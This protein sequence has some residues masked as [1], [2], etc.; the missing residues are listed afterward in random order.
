MFVRTTTSSKKKSSGTPYKPGYCVRVLSP[1]QMLSSRHHQLIFENLQNLARLPDEHYAA[2]Y[3]TLITHFADY[4]QVLPTSPR[5]GLSS[6]LNDSLYAAFYNLKETDKDTKGQASLLFRYA[7]FSASLLRKIAYVVEKYKI[8]ITNEKGLYI[9]EWAAFDSSM[10]LQQAEFYKLYPTG[11]LLSTNHAI[12][13]GMLVRL[14][15]PKA[16]FDWIASDTEL[17]HEWL[18]ILQ[19]EDYAEGRLGRACEH[20][21]RDADAIVNPLPDLDVELI[22]TPDTKHGEAFY[23]WIKNGL[24]DGSIKVNASDAHIHRVMDGV[25]IEYPGL[26][27]DFVSRVYTVPVNMNSVFEQFGNLFGLV[28]LSGDDY[29]NRQYFSEYPGVQDAGASKGGAKR[30]GGSIMSRPVVHSMRHGVVV[31]DASMLFVDGNVPQETR[32]LK[33]VDKGVKNSNALPQVAAR[34]AN[35]LSKSSPKK[36]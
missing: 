17:F 23:T 5:A 29:R 30:M 2:C 13:T 11:H 24:A 35:N 34:Y 3:Q 28:M 32:F 26:I 10:N 6:L 19:S 18:M 27:H 22:E 12:L 9:K 16:G 1:D 21:R 33:A 25:L 7:V 15:M 31:N 8:V 4:V 14:L 36:R 20:I